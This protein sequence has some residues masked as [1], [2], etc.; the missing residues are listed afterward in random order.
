MNPRV[1]AEL[2]TSSVFK[3]LP[4]DTHRFI[5]SMLFGPRKTTSTG[6]TITSKGVAL[7]VMSMEVLAAVP[8]TSRSPR[9]KPMPVREVPKL[10]KDKQK[11]PVLVRKSPRKHAAT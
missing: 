1:Y 2:V 10:R 6:G 4:E 9:P 11:K 7:E 5:L 8:K 3:K